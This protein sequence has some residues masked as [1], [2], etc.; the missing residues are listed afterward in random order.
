MRCE[1]IPVL[2]L[3]GG[4]VV[5]AVR[6]E[7]A[8]YRPIRTPL[9]EGA[10][11]EQ[12]GPA[13]LR[14]ADSNVLYVADLDAL[15]GGTVQVDALA[16]LLR[17]LRR[18]RPNA[19]L[20]LDGGWCDVGA[21]RATLAA[22]GPE[23]AVAVDPVL[24]SE[25]LRPHALDGLGDQGVLSDQV[26]PGG[27]TIGARTLLSLDRRDGRRLDPAG[28]WDRPAQWPARVIVMT[29]ER[30][31]ADA[32]PDLDTLA[33]VAARAAAGTVLIGAGGVRNDADL[34][35]AGRAGASGWLVASALHAGRLRSAAASAST[36]DG[37]VSAG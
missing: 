24:A 11:P 36:G 15:M 8:N 2:D 4:Q 14:A 3:L 31:G 13:L 5:H 30:V 35:A 28:C 7:R 22:L 34:Q 33:E 12:V 25:A 10:A 37:Q 26:G 21:M 32:G 19:R 27:D 20:W 23:L 9:C 18:E 1:L 29:L 16:G 17:A 6:G